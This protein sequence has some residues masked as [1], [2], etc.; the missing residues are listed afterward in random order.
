MA[1]IFFTYDGGLYSVSEETAQNPR[2]QRLLRHKKARILSRQEALTGMA[3]RRTTTLH[4]KK[5]R[6]K[7]S[8]PKSPPRLRRRPPQPTY[9][10]RFKASGITKNAVAAR[11]RKA[12]LALDTVD[13]NAYW[14]GSLTE[15]ENYREIQK[16]IT[17]TMRDMRGILW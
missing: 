7:K 4:V 17:P 13:I 15:A 8:P 12:G 3:Y 16:H 5:P 11:A 1:E 6:V 10:T 9:K 14:D 2:V